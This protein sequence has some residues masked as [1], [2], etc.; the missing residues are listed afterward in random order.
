VLSKGI[1][2]TEEDEFWVKPTEQNFQREF[3]ILNP[4][5]SQATAP[6][7]RAPPLSTLSQEKNLVTRFL[8]F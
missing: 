1:L 4:S 8:F 2:L 7:P 6:A 3:A 5:V